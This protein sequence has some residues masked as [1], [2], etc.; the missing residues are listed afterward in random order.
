[1]AFFGTTAWAFHATNVALHAANACLVFGLIRRLVD[2][3]ATALAGALLFAVHPVQAETVAWASETKDML[4]ALFALVAIHAYLS[5]RDRAR[6]RAY[7]VASVAFICALLAK[8]SAVVTPGLVLVLEGRLHPDRWR[9]SL[10]WLAPWF[11]GA[12]G[13]ALIAAHVQPATGRLAWV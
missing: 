6:F 12:T 5:F 3:E 4:S 9:T 2:G 11:V 13:F 7:L 8:P 10:R 1:S